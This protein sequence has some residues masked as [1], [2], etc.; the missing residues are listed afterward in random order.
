M[1]AD[2]NIRV[3]DADSVRKCVS[4]TDPDHHSV[5]VEE[6]EAVRV[7]EFCVCDSVTFRVKV[8]AAVRVTVPVILVSVIASVAVVVL[9]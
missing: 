4:D 5:M 3:L 1:D 8:I 2:R 6:I 7:T 9:D